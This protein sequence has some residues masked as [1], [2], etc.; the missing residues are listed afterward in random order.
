MI[1]G[2]GRDES[3]TCVSDTAHP[4]TY[5]SGNAD[6]RTEALALAADAGIALV[7][8]DAATVCILPEVQGRVEEIARQKCLAAYA[9]LRRPV[10]VEDVAL[11]FDAMGGLP[12][13]Y[14]RDFLCGMPL[15]HLYGLVRARDHTGVM[16]VSA[17]AFTRDGRDVCVIV[18]KARGL[19][20]DPTGYEHM[21]SWYPLVARDPE[22]ADPTTGGDAA[23]APIGSVAA[24]ASTADVERPC[25]HRARAFAALAAALAETPTPPPS[26]PQPTVVDPRS[27]APTPEKMS[28]MAE[29]TRT[30][31]ECLGEDVASDGLVDTPMRV[32]KAMVERTRGYRMNLADAVGGALFVEASRNMV[33]VRDI[34]FHSMCEHH[35]MAFK[36]HAHVGYMPMGMVIGLSKIP[37]IVDMFSERLQV[38][39]RLTRQIAEAVAEVTGA[40]GVGVVMEGEH[41]CMCMRG[42]RKTGSTTVTRVL[43]GAIRDDPTT[44]REFLSD[45]RP[46]ASK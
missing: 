13:P 39:E 37:R 40:C 12:G 6:K 31:L 10:V 11:H 45:A 32:A 46:R 1:A 7:C 34:E 24:W 43:L 27:L 4:I 44:R 20:R 19:V 5:V 29:A 28:L 16:A 30:L 22:D 38:Q 3:T 15:S 17:L 21:P 36:G 8:V 18:G 25:L 42:V 2:R 35:M 14:V 9:A 26:P 23:V 41:M 33:V